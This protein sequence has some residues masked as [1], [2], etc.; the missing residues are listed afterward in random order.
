MPAVFSTRRAMGSAAVTNVTRSPAPPPPRAT[1]AP[2]TAYS[3]SSSNAAL[4][5]SMSWEKYAPNSSVDVRGSLNF[6]SVTR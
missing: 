3:A 4:T 5:S 2:H 6:I 1:A